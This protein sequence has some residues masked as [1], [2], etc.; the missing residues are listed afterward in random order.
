MAQALIKTA[1]PQAMPGTTV[2][3]PS[4][5]GSQIRVV[6]SAAS[7]ETKGTP[8]PI[9]ATSAAFPSCGGDCIGT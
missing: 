8:A 2:G 9:A 7:T 1:H 5:E 6:I 4:T 3:S